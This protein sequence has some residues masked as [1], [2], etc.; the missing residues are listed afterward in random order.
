VAEMADV[1]NEAPSEA[2]E[3]P[4]P[5]APEA[6]LPKERAKGTWQ[7]QGFSM[8]FSWD[9][10]GLSGVEWEFYC[11]LMR[12]KGTQKNLRRSNGI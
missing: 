7:N 8:G 4:S 9:L 3:V 5:S 10:R 6:E 1:A 11:G 12:F 2:P